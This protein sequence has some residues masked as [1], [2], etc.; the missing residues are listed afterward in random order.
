MARIGDL[1][2]LVIVTGWHLYELP[3]QMVVAQKE[4]LE[5]AAD[6]LYTRQPH[7]TTST[8]S[9]TSLAIV[10]SAALRQ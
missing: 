7:Y 8:I 1:W 6:A 10:L 9:P 2:L 3:G 5:L 4:A